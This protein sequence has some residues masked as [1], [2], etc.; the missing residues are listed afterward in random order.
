M[1]PIR[2]PGSCRSLSEHSD[3][4]N[5]IVQEVFGLVKLS[6]AQRRKD[7]GGKERGSGKGPHVLSPPQ[8]SVPEREG[9]PDIISDNVPC[10]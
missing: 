10:R 4:G 8:H 7:A 2:I 3:A 6:G 9:A 5:W 1:M